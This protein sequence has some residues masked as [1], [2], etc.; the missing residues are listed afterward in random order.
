MSDAAASKTAM[1]KMLD[2]VER[3]GSRVHTPSSSS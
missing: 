3:V 2:V 1:Q